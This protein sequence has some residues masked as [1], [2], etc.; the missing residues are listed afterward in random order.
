MYLFVRFAPENL[1]CIVKPPKRRLE[2]DH[3]RFFNIYTASW[4]T[5]REMEPTL[6]WKHPNHLKPWQTVFSTIMTS[7]LGTWLLSWF[8][9][10]A[11]FLLRMGFVAL[12]FVAQ[13]SHEPIKPRCFF[14][15][16]PILGEDEPILTVR[17]FFKWVG[18]KNHQLS[19]LPPLRSKVSPQKS[20]V[21][22][23]VFWWRWFLLEDPPFFSASIHPGE[24]QQ[25]TGDYTFVDWRLG[26]VVY[27]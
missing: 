27:W 12:F 25:K 8:D 10:L 15:F 16:T 23:P 18:F 19:N 1:Q 24:M 26:E 2:L 6:C 21:V 11:P 22:R 7:S 13:I 4:K 14:I 9:Y 5:V 17:I 20:S 3:L